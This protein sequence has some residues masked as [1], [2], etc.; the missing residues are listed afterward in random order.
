MII[1]QNQALS[2][3]DVT[4][5]PQMTNIQSRSVPAIDTK[6]AGIDMKIPMISSPM[7][8]VTESRMAIAMGEEGGL[9]IVHRFC[10]VSEQLNILKEIQKH[11]SLIPRVAAIGIGDSE[12]ERFKEL[13]PIL[14]AV[15]IDVA[16]GHATY[17]SEMIHRVKDHNPNIKVIA[18]N[19]ATGKGF[20]YLANSG[21]DAVRVGIS[22]G[23][24]CKTRI[25]T[26]HGIP[27]LQSVIDAYKAKLAGGYFEVGI[28]ADG[29]I[30]YPADFVKALA[31]GADAV[32]CGRIFAAT[33]ETPGEIIENKNGLYCKTYR[34]A[35][36]AELQNERRGG[37][38]PFACAEGVSTQIP[39]NGSVKE[40][41]REFCGGLKSGMTYSNARDLKGLRIN[42]VFVRVS[43]SG[44]EE[45][46]AFGTKKQ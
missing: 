40:V 37:L 16:N 9:G 26:G 33:E 14:N 13:S 3:D 4:M 10:S 23:S 19:V 42:S 44:M 25:Q 39:L 35:A 8:T 12:F 2:F 17:V 7:D 46:H 24:I 1:S 22:G 31:A 43:Q 29:G 34:G 20:A 38:K 45:G 28:I 18:G 11:N 27:T 15:L 36:S 30:R 5:E 32:M 6:I 41:I 21:A